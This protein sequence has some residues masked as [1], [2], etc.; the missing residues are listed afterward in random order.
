MKDGYGNGSAI[1][2]HEA[3]KW[4]K[5][6]EE[7]GHPWVVAHD[8]AGNA[9]TGTPP[10]PD[11]PGMDEAAKKIRVKAPQLK[12]PTIDKIRSEVLWG[13]LM[14]GGDGVEYY[15]GYRLPQNDLNAEDWRSRAKT[16]KYSNI[17]LRFFHDN[18]IPFWE[19]TNTD[20]LVG[21][22]DHDNRAYC[23]SKP[24]EIYLV[25]FPS[26][27][28]PELNLEDVPGTFRVT[29]FNPRTG[30]DPA[31]GSVKGVKG[32]NRVDLGD[33]PVEDGMDWVVLVSR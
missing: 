12:L 17:A 20:E 27:D 8:E 7:S 9:A 16:W 33:P 30:G 1:L 24:G 13:N 11:Y 18:N 26:G 29:W 5:K 28:A 4:V 14:G 21:N 22:P 3:V 19:M 23:F 15:F 2:Y 31:Q 6:A 25:Y 10:D 32:N